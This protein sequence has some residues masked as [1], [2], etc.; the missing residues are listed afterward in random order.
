MNQKKRSSASGRKTVSVRLIK[1]IRRHVDIVKVVEPYVPLQRVGRHF[2]G[3]CP[4]HRER[5]ASLAVSP[6]RQMYYC[7]GCGAGGDIFAFMMGMEKITFRAAVKRL[8]GSI[9]KRAR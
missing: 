8:A 2:R 4:F 1:A 5:G 3:R 9:P 6:Q 7:L